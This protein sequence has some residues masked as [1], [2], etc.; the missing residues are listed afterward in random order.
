MSLVHHLSCCFIVI[1][2]KS[3]AYVKHSLDLSYDIL[4]TQEIL[5]GNLLT[6]FLEPKPLGVAK[7]LHFRMI[8]PDRCGSIL[9]GLTAL[10]VC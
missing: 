9:A 2:F 7:E 10:V 8:L 1:P 6:H 5:L 4:C 3:V